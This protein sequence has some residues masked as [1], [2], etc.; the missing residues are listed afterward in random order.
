MMKTFQ[1]KQPLYGTMANLWFRL[2]YSRTGV[3]LLSFRKNTSRLAHFHCQPWEWF[4]SS[5]L[6]LWN[7][8][9]DIS[10]GLSR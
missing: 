3:C 8:A 10:E 5:G 6:V 4:E 1:L 7:T 2:V 9:A